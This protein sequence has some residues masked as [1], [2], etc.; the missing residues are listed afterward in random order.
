MKPGETDRAV[1]QPRN[2][3]LKT[4]H[5]KKLK[6]IY[7]AVGPTCV[8]ICPEK[9]CPELDVLKK[10][11]PNSA[12]CGLG[13]LRSKNYLYYYIFMPIKRIRT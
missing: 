3:A 8:R 10:K 2:R 5:V 4:S 11:P 12:E 6:K 1:G 9:G 7:T 13:L